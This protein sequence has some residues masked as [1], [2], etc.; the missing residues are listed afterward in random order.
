MDEPISRPSHQNRAAAGLVA[1]VGYAR[2][3]MRHLACGDDREQS[4]AFEALDPMPVQGNRDAELRVIGCALCDRT[5]MI[6]RIAL[7]YD[8]PSAD[9]SHCYFPLAIVSK[10]ETTK[11]HRVS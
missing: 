4:A 9:I 2:S 5:T 7:T 1:N 10:D 8:V 3:L 6:R 11:D